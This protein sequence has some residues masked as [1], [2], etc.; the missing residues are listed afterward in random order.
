MTYKVGTDSGHNGLII[1]DGEDHQFFITGSDYAVFDF[2]VGGTYGAQAINYTN[3]IVYADNSTGMK[4]KGIR[5][6]VGVRMYYSDLYE[7]AYLYILPYKTL[8]I[9]IGLSGPLNIGAFGRNSIHH[10]TLFPWRQ[11]TQ[12]GLGDDAIQWGSDID[13]YNN[14]IKGYP[15]TYTYDQ[16]QD[17]IQI[18][19]SY[20][21]IYNNTFVDL[22]N[23]GVFV[24]LMGGDKAYNYIWN[25]IFYSTS[26]TYAGGHAIEFASRSSVISVSHVWIINN[27][28]VDKTQNLGY[29]ITNSSADTVW[30][31]VHVVNNLL[32][33]CGQLDS[34][35]AITAAEAP[36][37]SLEM[38]YNRAVA[39]SVGSSVIAPA[40]N[41]DPGGDSDLQFVTYSV[42]GGDSNNLRLA[43]SDT[44]AK[45]AGVNLAESAS[46]AITDKDG[47]MR[48]SVGNWSLGAYEYSNPSSSRRGRLR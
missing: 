35:S 25:N 23:C 20:V 19:A 2:V 42:Y 11:D 4:I 5:G 3:L 1:F 16:H 14:T 8:D 39:W 37:P 36:A 28:S 40:N 15:T 43:S 29:R 12:G 26:A 47:T 30:S 32:A 45:Q 34:S 27:T 22:G 10:C 31:D 44:G 21:R 38:A 48:P 7:L 46:F 13:I 41:P 17:G 6:A 24:E 33:N 9:I 18:N